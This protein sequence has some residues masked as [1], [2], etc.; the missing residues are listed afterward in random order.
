VT[1]QLK[2]IE[3]ALDDLKAQD[4]V[5]LSLEGKASFADYMV[6]ATGTSGRHTASLSDSVVETIKKHQHRSPHVEGKHAG[7]WVCVDDGDIV[8]HIFQPDTRKLYNL[9]KLWSF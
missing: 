1:A 6:I 8:I 7:E 4:I 3:K 5:I 9:E 2:H